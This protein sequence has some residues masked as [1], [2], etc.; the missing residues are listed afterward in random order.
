MVDRK[1]RTLEEVIQLIENNDYIYLGQHQSK[2]RIKYVYV[3]D[4]F[5]YKYHT[6]LD[7]I[8]NKTKLWYVVK[9]NPFSLENIS[10][11]LKLNNKTFELSSDNVYKGTFDKLKFHCLVCF[12]EFYST[13]DRI[14]RG[15]GCGFCSGHKI[16]KINNLK[17]RLPEIAI[18]FSSEN[19]FKAEDVTIYSTKTAIW[20][21]H[22]CGH[23]WRPQVASR[24]YNKSECPSCGKSQV[25]DNNRFLNLYPEI[26]LEWHPIKNNILL[27][28]NVSYGSNKKVW[29]LC[30]NCGHE[31]E[32]PIISRTIGARTCPKCSIHTKSKGEENI[33]IFL[34]KKNINY[35]PQHKF[36]DC[37]NINL[38]L[39][40][41][42]L[43]NRNIAIEFQ[44]KQHYYNMKAW[45]E[46]GKLERTIKNDNIKK[47]YCD[48]KNIPLLIIPYWM[49]D[50]VD[51]IL[52]KY[53][54]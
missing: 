12:E 46:N 34:N 41:F 15:M 32:S 22:K 19:N 38:L 44:G 26:A 17:Y 29:W 9:G 39:F 33:S 14:S 27:P 7:R 37:K 47:K 53:L 10:L 48:D 4:K 49:V 2:N 40:D 45:G 11:W 35:I 31:W 42:Y 18:D 36:L 21:C 1:R 13:W 3:Q 5:G 25:V 54:A 28:E 43:P 23:V 52:E 6:S 50:K 8:I 30:F 16:G 20:K 24:T 51:V